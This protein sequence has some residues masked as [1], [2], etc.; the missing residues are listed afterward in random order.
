MGRFYEFT[1][2][3]IHEAAKWFWR[4][5]GEH[6]VVAIH[7]PMGAGKTSF[8]HALCD[9]KGVCDPVSSPTF[10]LVNE[11]L[12]PAG[13]KIYHIDLYRIKDEEEAVQA[14]IEDILFSGFACFVEWPEKAPG[15]F[16]PKTV[17][18]ELKVNED[19]SRT[20]KLL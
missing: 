20:I 19:Q 10:S 5:V 8:V 18:A 2:G 3:T 16:P 1:L 12:D 6:A 7:G 11:Y 14:G 9:V 13:E 4:E 17:E 15:I